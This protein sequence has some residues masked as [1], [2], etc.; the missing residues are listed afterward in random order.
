MKY[1][2]G[3][4]FSFE[5]YKNPAT[6]R[7]LVDD[8]LID[9]LVLTESIE[10][11]GDI[12]YNP[13]GMSD[14]LEFKNTNWRYHPKRSLAKKMYIYEVDESILN[15]YIRLEI[16]NNNT[17]H[18]NGFITKYSYFIFDLVFL[19][20]KK[21]FEDLEL[22]SK[23]N[24]E[25]RSHGHGII[26][27]R[28]NFA[29]KGLADFWEWPCHHREFEIESQSWKPEVLHNFRRGGSFT[30]SFDLARHKNLVVIKPKNMPRKI[31][32]DCFWIMEPYFLGYYVNYYVKS[33][34]LNT[35]N[36][37]QRSDS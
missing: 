30:Y 23:E 12:N 7:I 28:E 20:P 16:E 31:M 26:G 18:T 33:K 4:A 11:V 10:R 19:L 15:H 29:K 14:T 22:M 32:D 25:L 1:I 3:L 24:Q 6:L 5:Y 13:K 35:Y 2:L 36:E 37:D 8:V 17:N 34:I 9:E 27:P 21:Y